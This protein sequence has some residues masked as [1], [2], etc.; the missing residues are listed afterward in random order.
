[1]DKGKMAVMENDADK[2]WK[3]SFDH[4]RQLIE[5]FFNGKSMSGIINAVQTF[6]SDIREDGLL[7]AWFEK[8]E[9]LFFEDA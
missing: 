5:N 6:A 1:M 7:L 2:E 3:I 8:M 4:A 9:E